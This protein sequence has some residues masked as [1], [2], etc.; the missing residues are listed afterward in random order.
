M[1]ALGYDEGRNVHLD[2]RNL[3]DE[4]AAHGAATALV[5]D[6]VDVIVASRL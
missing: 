5:R 3:A 6:R 1:K 4:T 2:W